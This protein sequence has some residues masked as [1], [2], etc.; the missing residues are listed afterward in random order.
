MKKQTRTFLSLVLSLCLLIGC[1]IPM[2]ASASED[3]KAYKIGVAFYQLDAQAI[4]VQKYLS[5]YVGPAFNVE[6][7]F[8][9]A[10]AD[11]ETL[12]NFMENAYAA[13]CDAIMNYQNSSIDQAIAKANELGIYLVTNTTTLAD[14]MD[15]PYNLGYVAASVDQCAKDFGTLVNELMSDGE[16]HNVIIVSAGAG[17]GNNEHFESTVAILKTLQD[18]Y[19]LTYEDDIVDLAAVRSETDVKSDK[20]IKITIYP[21]Y[22]NSDTY[23][24][25][26]S[27]LLQT[28]EYDT[29]LACNAA[30]AQCSVAID[31]VEKAYG[32][33]IR[34]SAI[35]N[36]SDQT[37]TNFN[38]LD[39]AGNSSLNSA[40]LMPSA[41]TAAGMFVL[42]YN[43]ITGNAEVVRVDG[44]GIIY[45]ANK[46]TC[47]NADEYARIE[48][49]NTSDETYEISIDELKEMLV[50]FN[51]EA[52]SENIMATL[53]GVTVESVL[54]ARGI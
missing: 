16:K 53:Y 40:I 18:V 49:L 46:W 50:A 8:S 45:S 47:R 30:Y 15:L 23:V 11:V 9:E 1:S 21:G 12:I 39:S 17:M 6:F 5:E 20:D 44:T 41:A 33:D 14:N 24:P 42:A 43:G 10:V 36:I 31:E 19:G 26:M 51:P 22:P 37:R 48:M 35:T 7:M 52:T 4:L 27:A 34:I 29:L 3:L 28:G 54:N 25:G 13:G 2:Q 32:I 38:T